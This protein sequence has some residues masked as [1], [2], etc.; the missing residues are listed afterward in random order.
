MLERRAH[1]R[2]AVCDGPQVGPY[3]QR[4]RP[5]SSELRDRV[6]QLT[7]RR[8][9]DE[10]RSQAERAIR[11]LVF[12][13]RFADE[14]V[15]GIDQFADTLRAWQQLA[16]QRQALRVRFRRDERQA[17]DVTARPSEARDESG[18]HRIRRP[19]ENDRDAACRTLRGQ[20]GVRARRDDDFRFE[21]NQLFG[22]QWEKLEPAAGIAVVDKQVFSFDPAQLARRRP[23][24]LHLRRRV[25]VGGSQP[26]DLP[27]LLLRLCARRGPSREE[28]AR[29]D[30]DEAPAFHHRSSEAEDSPIVQATP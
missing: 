14:S 8:D 15:L 16:Q 5:A 30:A 28:R 24:L 22:Q 7:R 2:L 4:L 26:C 12:G 10:D 25:W 9:F 19:I 11:P 20:R 3:D 29:G 18:P 13:L 27:N 21:A 6:L 1:D 23:E 17:R